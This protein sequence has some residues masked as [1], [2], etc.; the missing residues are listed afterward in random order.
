M[1][2]PQQPSRQQLEAAG[3]SSEAWESAPSVSRV[4]GLM[5]LLAASSLLALSAALD[6]SV[7]SNQAALRHPLLLLAAS[8]TLSAVAGYLAPSIL[9]RR[10]AALA[11]A[12][13]SAYT[14]ARRSLS[15]ES[16]VAAADA[17]AAVMLSATG[18]AR[19]ADAWPLAAAGLGLPAVYI[20]ASAYAEAWRAASQARKAM[21]AMGLR[22]P[23]CT[24]AP[25]PGAAAAALAATLG[26]ASPLLTRWMH[27]VEECINALAEAAYGA[28]GPRAPR[29]EP[30]GG[31]KGQPP[32]SGE[33][34]QSM[35]EHEGSRAE[36][37]MEEGSPGG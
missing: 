33:D 5:G 15:Y 8:S 19:L 11:R 6:P 28:A 3:R 13:D 26:L 14:A 23:G 4:L 18:L 27:R 37:G 22:V 29:E 31:E 36:E 9:A 25:R 7:A 10:V 12:L 16:R 2:T 17:V 32:S 35:E 20:A 24:P 1:S 30:G 34:G 21:E